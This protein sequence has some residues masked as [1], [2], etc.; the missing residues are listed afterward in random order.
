MPP[1]SVELATQ[2]LGISTVSIIS[3]FISSPSI[4][5]IVT[6][7]SVQID[8]TSTVEN[9][10]QPSTKVSSKDKGKEEDIDLDEDI[11]ILNWNISTLNPNQMHIV[12]EL[13]QKK[14]KQ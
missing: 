10:S 11:V 2:Q 12:G 5:T 3:T 8:G 4:S 13:L 14:D 7:P 9:K 1:P 6:I